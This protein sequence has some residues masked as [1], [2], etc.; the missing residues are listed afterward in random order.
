[1]N[2][3]CDMSDGWM[4]IV[5]FSSTPFG[6]KNEVDEKLGIVVTWI[7]EGEDTISDGKFWLVREI[8]NEA[9]ELVFIRLI[10]H[11]N[12]VDEKKP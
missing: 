12:Q 6:W 5:S 11:P 10:F 3:M 2:E 8:K 9:Y 1:M 4:Q 7:S